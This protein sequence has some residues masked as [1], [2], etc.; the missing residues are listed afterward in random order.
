M[1][2]RHLLQSAACEMPCQ[3]STLALR[4]LLIDN[5]DSFTYI[6]ADYIGQTFGDLPKI[7]YNDEYSWS[8]L[9]KNEHIDCI[10]VSPGPGS[11]VNPIDVG[12]S[13]DA[14]AQSDIP[15]FGVCLGMQGI[16]HRHGGQ[17][18]Y[19]PEPFHGRTSAIEHSGDE[20][21]AH[22]PSSFEVV[23][24]HSLMASLPKDGRLIQ[25]AW[26]DDG[27]VQAIRHKYLPQWGVQFHPE[28]IL[29]EHGHQI[30]SNFRDL[31]HR[32]I[33]KAHIQVPQ[34]LKLAQSQNNS[35][36]QNIK[37]IVSKKVIA[38]HSA[39]T[40]FSALFAKQPHSFWLDSQSTGTLCQSRFS[41]MGCVEKPPEFCYQIAKDN[42]DYAQG[43]ALLAKMDDLLAN[44][45]VVG[46]E[47]LPFS[48]VGG[49]VG[50]FSYEMKALFGA[51]R[52]HDNQDSPDM[53]WLQVERFIA[54]DHH[55]N[56]LYLVFCAF[57]EEIDEA[58]LWLD[59]IEQQLMSV[60]DHQPQSN[61]SIKPLSIDVDF[62]VEQYL[63][64]VK[65]CQEAIVEG[66]SY[67]VCL[68]NQF[69]LDADLD[70]YELYLS[71]R[72]GNSA[73]YGA[74]IKSAENAVLST[75]PE[76]FLEVAD[77]GRIQA[78]PIK[79]TSQRSNDPAKDQQLAQALSQSE[80]DRSE[81]LMIVDLMRNDLSR[82]SKPA[83]V[84][85]P[86][87]MDIES[88]KTVHQMVSTIESQLSDDKSL[89]DL[90]AVTFPGGSISGA[91][92][93]RTMEII[94]SLEQS[95]RG[96]Y[97][98]AIG[99]LGYNRVADLNIGIR[100]MAYNQKTLRFGAGGAVTYLSDPQAEFDE[101]L[102]KAEALIKPLWH[103]LTG[104]DG[105]INCQ[106]DNNR[107]NVTQSEE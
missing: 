77:G 86:V 32:F 5:Y 89:M 12:I 80:K 72:K 76:R 82:V 94:D 99:Y 65:Q 107:L 52:A 101:M 102:L 1:L 84:R 97:C 92:K 60:S 21:F 95:A 2:H 105:P 40:V 4:C 7:V 87:L 17:I 51:Q 75:S 45:K 14:I 63:S 24:Y 61:P 88:Y 6:L 34:Q 20:M 67:E 10:V 11:V 47:V 66:D 73:P 25:T 103:H 106:L 31:S 46:A 9:K 59:E 70:P 27:V 85:V 8:E 28:S 50:Y 15:L 43:K 30:L 37:H 49:L 33:N 78:K 22:I 71:M 62:G 23:R 93:I 38:E 44:T 91:P 57:E 35:T 83:S 13:T 55:T 18:H 69:S 26:S 100:T 56:A 98:G 42:D 19:C 29:T 3:R 16:H 81:N 58:N 90:I 48:F 96:V 41:F 74:F 36:A 104:D 54:F 64:A 53:Q 79:G 68:T 39:E